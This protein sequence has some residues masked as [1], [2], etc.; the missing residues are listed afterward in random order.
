MTWCASDANAWRCPYLKSDWCCSCLASGSVTSRLPDLFF[1]LFILSTPYFKEKD[2]GKGNSS[3]NPADVGGHSLDCLTA[4]RD[5]AHWLS[6]IFETPTLEQDLLG[7]SEFEFVLCGLKR[8]PLK[9]DLVVA[10]SLHLFVS[11]LL[12]F[13]ITEVSDLKPHHSLVVLGTL[14]AYSQADEADQP[15]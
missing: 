9:R 8:G 1:I 15:R 13:A 6:S 3:S 7:L 5:T 10:M 4:C 14:G 11:L 2:V 12:F